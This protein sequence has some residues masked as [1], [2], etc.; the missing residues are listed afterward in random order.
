MYGLGCEVKKNWYFPYFILSCL[1]VVLVCCLSE[2]YISDSGK[3]Y[4]IMEIMLLERDVMLTDISFNRFNMWK[5]G[6]GMWTQMALPFLLSIGY[7]NIISL[8]NK[9]EVIRMQLIREN[10]CKYAFSKML[11][12]MINGGVIMLMGYVLFGVLMCVR[13]PSIDEYAMA[14][15]SVY[16]EMSMKFADVLDSVRFCSRV[17]L[18]GVCVNIFAYAVSIFFRDKYVLMC[19]PVMLK[20]IWGQVILKVELDAM[21]DGNS[22]LLN[23]CSVFRI[24]NVL[25]MEQPYSWLITLCA[26]LGIYLCLFFVMMILLQKREERIG[27][28]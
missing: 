1:G 23:V 17:L 27:F 26:V 8:E 21:N 6:I 10:N 19:L 25:N 2:G 15:Q 28:E 13:F 9:M 18:Y 7:M 4:T 11:A 24:E 12:I 3:T 5:Q 22:K 16:I 14:N 20:Y